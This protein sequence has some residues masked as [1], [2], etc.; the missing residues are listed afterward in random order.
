VLF[1]IYYYYDQIK[2]D[3]MGGS[4]N[5]VEDVRNVYKICSLKMRDKWE[6]NIDETA[7]V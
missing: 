6:N 2:E 5:T 1:T 3:E 4:C 7:K